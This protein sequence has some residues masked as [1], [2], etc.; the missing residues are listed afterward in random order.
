MPI[1]TLSFDFDPLVRF[2]DRAFRLETLA[3]AAIV[4][5]TLLATAFLAR[6]TPTGPGEEALRLD[7][8]VFVALGVLPGAVLGGRLGYVLLHLD[9]YLAHPAAT[10]DPEQG[11]LGLSL[12]VVGG[13][14]TG[15]YV[16]RLLE[17]PV[18]RWAHVAALPL[19]ALLGL[20]KVAMALGG[21]GQ[22]RPSDEPWA[23]AYLGPGPWGSLAPALPSIPSQLLEAAGVGLLLVVLV[24]LLALGAFARRDGRLLVVALGGWAL[25]RVVVASTWRDPVILGPFRTNQLVDLAIVGGCLLILL[26]VGRVSRRA[27]R[28]TQSEATVQWPAPEVARTWRGGSEGGGQPPV[29]G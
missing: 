6:R 17:A 18:G 23:T 15:L 19:L 28:R 16:V 8:L 11:A 22:G 2:G 12:G 24:A 25:V 7:D 4:F 27:D 13:L 3:L 14:V 29:D 26:A 5:G 21:S 10:V 9:Y 1:A 20:G